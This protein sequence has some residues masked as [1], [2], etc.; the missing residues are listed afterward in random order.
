[1]GFMEQVPM[2]TYSQISYLSLVR[3]VQ[4]IALVSS[5]SLDYKTRDMGRK[6]YDLTKWRKYN[7][8]TAQDCERRRAQLAKQTPTPTKDL[9]LGKLRV[10]I[11]FPR[12]YFYGHMVRFPDNAED[13]LLLDLDHWNF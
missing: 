4:L 6:G 3:D 9:V 2:D 11:R 12:D 10:C 5:Y 1:M 8:V 7:V 13:L